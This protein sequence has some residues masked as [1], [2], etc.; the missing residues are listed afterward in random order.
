MTRLGAHAS[1]TH[2]VYPRSC[3]QF[4]TQNSY[5]KFPMWKVT[6]VLELTVV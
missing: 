5:G 4:E 3:H 1:G 6:T 2:F